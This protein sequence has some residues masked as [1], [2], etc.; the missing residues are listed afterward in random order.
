MFLWLKELM[1]A[2]ECV[3]ILTMSKVC[4]KDI[5]PLPNVNKLVKGPSGFIILI[6][7]DT[8]FKYNQI[9]MP[10]EDQEKNSLSSWIMA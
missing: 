5:Y 10:I 8:F 3:W 1:G 6:F 2:R 4:C 9:L 7:Y